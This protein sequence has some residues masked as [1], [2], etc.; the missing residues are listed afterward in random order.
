MLRQ[1]LTFLMLLIFLTCAGCS[2]DSDDPASPTKSG[3]SVVFKA[4]ENDGIPVSASDRILGPSQP[5]RENFAGEWIV[6]VAQEGHE[7]SSFLLEIVKQAV[8]SD[9]E[10]ERSEYNV[11]V[12]DASPQARQLKLA[13]HRI[14]GNE[15]HIRFESDEARHMLF[16][17]TLIE[18]VVWGN[19]QFE[20]GMCFPTLLRPTAVRTLQGQRL[21]EEIPGYADLFQTETIEDVHNLIRENPHSGLTPEAFAYAVKMAAVTKTPKSEF[22]KLADDALEVGRKWGPRI[23]FL[24]RLQVALNMT[25]FSY[26]PDTAAELLAATDVLLKDDESMSR[27]AEAIEATKKLVRLEQAALLTR[28]EDEAEQQQGEATLHALLKDQPF[29]S[30]II[31]ALAELAE[32]RGQTDKA[33]VRFAELT[34]LPQVETRL[35]KQWREFGIDKPIPRESLARLWKE[36]H[37]SFDGIQ[38]YLVE[39][40][41]DR[42]F[43]FV[44]KLDVSRSAETTGNRTTLFELFTGT[45]CAACVG[46]DLALAGAARTYPQT[47]LIVLRYHQH[48]VA[49]DPLT[50]T[51]SESRSVS[52]GV[53]ATPAVF[54]NGQPVLDFQGHLEHVQNLYQ[55]IRETTDAKAAETTPVTITA[56]VKQ[57]DR[58][59]EISVEVAGIEKLTDSHRLYLALAEDKVLLHGSNGLMH[60]EMVVRK[61]IGGP[62]GISADNNRLAY[63]GTISLDKL[64]DRLRNYLNQYEAGE[65][66]A[67][68]LRPLELKHFHLVAFV[69]DSAMNEDKEKN[70]VLQAI[71][72]P[73]GE[74]GNEPPSGKPAEGANAKPS[75]GAAPPPL[76][77]SK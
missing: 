36:K 10:T 57:H 2:D 33:I 62:E 45:H 58:E 47:R 15:I 7:V 48:A 67:F 35:L 60:H 76:P 75:D 44:Q 46:A 1:Y 18:G 43:N 4:K 77:K 65:G 73:I 27:Y 51:D 50:N 23:E 24:T 29:D 70:V 9:T 25:M 30:K 12:L 72:V 55:F 39:I 17:G 8:K 11:K 6:V 66:Y 21:L 68:P 26:L 53:S 54:L 31:L 3:D 52:Y 13:E 49:P 61:L 20:N 74:K 71:A 64:K 56:T 19:S 28:S 22:L 5:V 63:S 42:I 41:D 32:K 14:E 16:D 34:A 69:Q 38:D 59:L 40:Y 37:G